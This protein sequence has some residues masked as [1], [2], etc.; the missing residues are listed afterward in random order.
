MSR[1]FS[2]IVT[3]IALCA[4][5]Q[6]PPEEP[7]VRV[8]SRAYAPSAPSGLAAGELFLPVAVA[9][10][11][12]HGRAVS[13]LKSVDFQLSDQGKEIPIEAVNA[14]G[15]AGHKYIAL[16]FD[17]YGSS[18]GQLLRAK[19][20]AVRFV[21]DGIAAD[22]LVSIATT[23]SGRVTDFIGDKDA[24]VGAIERIQQH[25]TPLLAP[26]T[27]VQ[28]GQIPG[29][30]R[31]TYDPPAPAGQSSTGIDLA[32]SGEFISRHFLDL[33]SAYDKDL[34]KMRGG[35]AI[36]ILSPGFMGMPEKEQDA[37]ISQTAAANVVINVIDTKSALKES[38]ASL[39]EPVYELPPSTYT[40]TVSRLGTEQAMAVFAADTGGLFFHRDGDQFSRGYREFG[41]IPAVTYLLAMHQGEGEKFRRIE[42]AL[43]TP[44]SNQMGAS[45]LE[46][47]LGY[48]PSKEA[49][50][51]GEDPAMRA[52]LDAQVLSTKPAADFP[53]KP[54]LGQSTKLA[55]GKIAVPVTL[56]VDLKGLQFGARNNRHTQKLTFVAAVLDPSG[57]FVAGKEGSMEFALTDGKF[58]S[59]KQQGVNASLVLEVPAGQYRLSTV[60]LDADGKV[61]G[62][63]NA[64]QVP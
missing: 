36:V 11:D 62:S 40:F 50:A 61:A 14:F 20:V 34:A 8:A 28:P 25:A 22:D 44:G 17:D 26:P 38:P 52:R 3:V 5:A 16:C 15:A 21:R 57:N 49:A 58:E 45:H 12:A 39:A 33:I 6:R 24:L 18:T 2:A 51:P 42:V 55:N 47:R 23:F 46:A 1:G 64:I 13:G 41:D 10:R 29:K 31:S 48:Y 32:W 54:S 19:S 7:E 9:V 43:K 35:R 63:L 59:M 4:S 30:E 60:A 37:V 27:R 53:L 56:H